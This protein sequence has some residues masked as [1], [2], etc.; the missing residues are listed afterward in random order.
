MWGH[1]NYFDGIKQL[2]KEGN[3]AFVHKNFISVDWAAQ[4]GNIQPTKGNKK[5]IN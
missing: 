3:I 4:T 1:Q 5:A 2:C